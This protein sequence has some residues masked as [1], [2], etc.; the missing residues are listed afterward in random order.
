MHGVVLDVDSLHCPLSDATR[1][2]IGAA[3]LARMKA[4]AILINTA[5]GGI[6]DEQALV[7]AF[8]LGAQRNA[9]N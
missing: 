2:L 3:E 6:V 9:V 1:N 7:D 8:Q 4:G 5:R